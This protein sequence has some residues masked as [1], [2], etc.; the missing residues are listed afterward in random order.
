MSSAGAKIEVE[1]LNLW[2]GD[3]QGLRD[4]TMSVREKAITALIGSSGCGKSTLLR[5]LNRMN[6]L[7]ED[8][9]IEG[10]VRIDGQD[11][12][13]GAGGLTGLRKSHTIVLVT[14]NTKQAARVG[15]RTAFFL[16]GDMIEIGPTA[17]VFTTP[18]DKR[19]EDYIVGRFG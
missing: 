5:C 8:V 19:T 2:Y 11:I 1:R 7:I 4:V 14:N 13:R 9:R 16:M 3:F 15:T 18:D 10:A 17:K 12:Y 6:D